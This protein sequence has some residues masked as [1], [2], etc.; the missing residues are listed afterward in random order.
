MAIGHWLHIFSRLAD[1]DHNAEHLVCFEEV[2]CGGNIKRKIS[3][4][5]LNTAFF[6]HCDTSPVDKLSRRTTEVKISWLNNGF[7][8]LTAKCI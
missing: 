5:N 6:C 4:R 1:C 8:L 3:V 7:D 2:R